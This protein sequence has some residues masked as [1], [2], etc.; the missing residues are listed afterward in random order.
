[1]RDSLVYAC[2]VYLLAR[3]TSSIPFNEARAGDRERRKGGL[4]LPLVRTFAT[5]EQ[6]NFEGGLVID[7]LP[8]VRPPLRQRS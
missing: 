2:K 3:A 1:M 7:R 8:R 4:H 5:V 6:P